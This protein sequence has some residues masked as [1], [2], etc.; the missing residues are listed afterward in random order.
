M[1]MEKLDSI[2][3]AQERYTPDATYI[4]Q[5]RIRA[6]ASMAKKVVREAQICDATLINVV[7]TLERDI[8]Y[9]VL[10]LAEAK[11]F[12]DGKPFM[13]AIY[14]CPP[15]KQN[16]TF[17]VALAASSSS[18]LRGAVSHLH[19]KFLN[20]VKSE[21]QLDVHAWMWTAEVDDVGR[22][23]HD[24]GLLWDVLR[25]TPYTIDPLL[26][27]PGARTY[28][29]LM[30]TAQARLI[31]LTAKEAQEE[32]NPIQ[33]D[34]QHRNVLLVDIRPASQR[35]EFGAIPGSLHV[36]RVLLESSFDVKSTD[37]ST[38]KVDRFDARVILFDQDG[39]ASALAATVLHDMGLL[40]ATDIEGGFTAWRESGFPITLTND[41]TNDS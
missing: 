27:P 10:V 38:R 9:F 7:D 23:Q 25:K 33:M 32:T 28:L 41:S 19:S 18:L 31:R 3:K 34:G 6:A 26:A 1:S 8:D 21:S 22:G 16:A 2:V 17:P 5:V 24:L 14:R 29:Q 11:K 30:S 12:S 35:E 15:H 36:E 13:F 37:S 4:T 40:K 39:T 20:R